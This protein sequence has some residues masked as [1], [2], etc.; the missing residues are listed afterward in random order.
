MSVVDRIDFGLRSIG[1]VERERFLSRGPGISGAAAVFEVVFSVFRS[2]VGGRAG[3][4]VL[5]AV[6]LGSAD[7]IAFL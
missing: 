6:A 1:R 2:D 5:E 4:A 3:S 7:I